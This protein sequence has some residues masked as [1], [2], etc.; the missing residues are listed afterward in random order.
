MLYKE[1]SILRKDVEESLNRNNLPYEIVIEMDE[2]DNLK[3]FVEMG[4][5]ISILSSMT[6]TREDKNRFVIINVNNL[7]DK[8]DYG[9]YCRK[10]KFFTSSMREFLKVFA[11]NLFNDEQWANLDSVL[12]EMRAWNGDTASTKK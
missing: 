11:P 9:I 8:I 12:S 6:I 3:K 2:A 4:I 10:N 1:G 7:F 5:G